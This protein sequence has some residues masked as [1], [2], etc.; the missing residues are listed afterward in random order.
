MQCFQK[1]L[2]KRC[3]IYHDLPKQPL[4]V[5]S[6]LAGCQ[7]LHLWHPS[8]TLL[9]EVQA[10]NT[11]NE[12]Q[13]LEPFTRR[14]L[15]PS[16]PSLALCS[17][18][19][20]LGRMNRLGKPTVHQC[21]LLQGGLMQVSHVTPHLSADLPTDEICDIVLLPHFHPGEDKSYSRVSSKANWFVLLF[22]EEN[23]SASNKATAAPLS[24]LI[25][26]ETNQNTL[27][28]LSGQSQIWHWLN[29]IAYFSKQ[30]SRTVTTTVACRRVCIRIPIVS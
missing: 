6:D 13:G 25:W 28:M 18:Y 30:I 19:D 22:A 23:V 17:T 16:W 29:A 3:A 10:Q 9:D 12:T 21:C 8:S 15:H 1:A 14:W 4:S 5:F 27:M 7:N 24:T 26:N 2:L 11:S 20:E